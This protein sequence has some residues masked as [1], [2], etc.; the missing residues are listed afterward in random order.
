L[1]R[2]RRRR[3]RH[4]V[5]ALTKAII[6]YAYC[7]GFAKIVIG[8][9][10]GIRHGGNGNSKANT[11]VHNFWSFD[12]I[13][14]RFREKAEEC[15]IEVVK[16]PEG[17]TSSTC[18]ECRS[19][20]TFRHKRLFKCLNCGFEAHR[21][22]IG[23]LNIAALHTRGRPAIRVVAHPLLLRWN[24]MRWEPKRA[25][26]NQPMNALEARISRL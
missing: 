2:A 18:P 4:A 8:D 22:V 11:M 17:R 9:L 3:F 13:V 21:D 24:G 1:Y 5:S 19:D 10:K 12:Y 15:G 6:E 20:W 14:R 7:H 16:K 25:M 23:V 26:N